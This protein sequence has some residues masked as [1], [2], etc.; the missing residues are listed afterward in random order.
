MRPNYQTRTIRLV[1]EQQAELAIA[2]L[3]HAPIDAEHPLEVV[4]REERKTRKPDQNSAMW[5][6]P[7]RDIAEQAWVDRR[8]FAVETWHEYYKRKYLP[9]DDD[10][11]IE[12][13]AKEGYRKW[14]IDPAGERVL[15]GSTTQLT[16]RG[17]A[18]YM[19]QIHAHGGSL[20]VQFH[21]A[22]V[23]AAA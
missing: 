14:A 10:P 17:M 5:S 6:G 11:E 8:Q 3:R 15:I 20:G 16:V 1:G 21:A 19:E 18:V 7:L 12:L 9:E 4:I 22:P 13:L 2:A 23:R